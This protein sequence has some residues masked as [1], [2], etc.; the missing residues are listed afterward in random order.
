[1][2]HSADHTNLKAYSAY[3]LPS[4]EALVR[5]FHAAAGFPVRTTWLNAIKVGN[6]RTWPGLILADA[7]AYYPSAYETIKGHIVQSRQ[8]ARST[9]PKIPQR[10]I[11]DTSP[12]EAPLPT[13][14]SR[15]LNMNT[16]HISKLYTD[17]TGKFPIKERSG[18]QYL[19]VAYH[20]YSNAILVAPF[21]TRKY[22]H[23]LE[24]YKS[25]ITRLRKNGMSVNL[26][27]LDN[28]AR[29]KFKHLITEDLGIKYQLVPPDIHRRNAAER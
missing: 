17:D 4:V 20:C 10:Q 26:K 28:E 8:G 7:T 22:K 6:S 13:T 29:S 19:M 21:K 14:S 11:P 24:A 16:V 15:E 5:Y 27:I 3:D 23:R 9:K 2:P 12:E 1:M 25:I 18:N